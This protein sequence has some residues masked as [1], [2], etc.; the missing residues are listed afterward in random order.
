MHLKMVQKLNLIENLAVMYSAGLSLVE[1]LDALA[2]D[3]SPN[4]KKIIEGI[5]LSISQGR[6]LTHGLSKFKDVFDPITINLLSSAEVSGTLDKALFKT[7]KQ[8]KKQLEFNEKIISAITY[9]LIIVG[10]FIGVL[11]L[12][13]FVIIPKIAKVFEDLRVKVPPGTQ[14]LIS[15]SKVYVTYPLQ[16]VLITF[17]IIFLAI[18]TLIYKRKELL[19]VVT[20]IPGIAKFAFQI[21]LAKFTG[22]LGTLLQSGIPIT[23]AIEL[24]AHAVVQPKLEKA[25][26]VCKKS[27]ETGNSLS[28]GMKKNK[29]LFTNRIIAM[30]NAGEKSGVLDISLLELSERITSEA[31]ASLKKLTILIEPIL[32]LVIGVVVG[33][34]MLSILSPIYQLIGGVGY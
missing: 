13:F 33:I 32:L 15:I 30:I 4:E 16:S 23:E 17:L 1:S 6:S 26:Q 24:A 10:I 3:A 19:R 14:L 29:K 25:I 7:S 9:P 8:I 2:E 18:I 11:G 20:R 34:T 22:S 31:D 28:F 5:R 21:D 12:I 27:V